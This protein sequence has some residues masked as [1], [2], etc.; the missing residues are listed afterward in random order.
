MRIQTYLS[1][2]FLNNILINAKKA[3]QDLEFF[4][5]KAEITAANESILKLNGKK[6]PKMGK[7]FPKKWKMFSTP[8]IACM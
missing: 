1:I 2:S 3:P 6:F 5:K 7:L 8:A 4:M